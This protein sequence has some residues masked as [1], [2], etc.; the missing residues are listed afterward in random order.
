MTRPVTVT[1]RTGLAQAL[2]QLKLSGM[3]ATLDARLAQAAAGD[4]GNLDDDLARFRIEG[5][6][7]GAGLLDQV[8]GGADQ[9]HVGGQRAVPARG[10]GG[11]CVTSAAFPGRTASLVTVPGRGMTFA[12]DAGPRRNAAAPPSPAAGGASSRSVPAARMPLMV[13]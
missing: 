1:D 8:R 6:P 2:R 11:H 9:A 5:Q 13:R 7:G 3:L 12:N 10:D 4:L